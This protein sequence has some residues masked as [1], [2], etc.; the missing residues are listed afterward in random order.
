MD[1]KNDRIDTMLRR[2]ENLKY[3]LILDSLIVGILVGLV[4]VVHR[5]ILSGLSPIFISFYK[6]ASSNYLLIPVVFLVLILLGFIVGR[7]VKKEPMISGSG[8]PQVEG[9]L[10]RNLKQNWFMVLLYKFIGGLI[11]LGAGLSLGREGPSVQMG[12]CIGEGISKKTK[13]LDNE[14]KYLITSGAS[15][16]LSAAFNAPISGVMFSLEETHKNFSPLVLL[17]AMIASLTADFISKNFFGLTPSLYFSQLSSLPLKYYW[18]LLIL[19][20]VIGVSGV[21]FSNGLLKTQD[22]YKKINASVEVK[23]IIPFVITGIIGLI[24]PIVLGGGHDL[25]MTLKDSEF[26]LVFLLLVIV[27][28]FLFTFVCFGSGA[29]GG[30][31]FPLLVLG[32]LVG[33]F[34][35]IIYVK[36][37][38]IPG[39]YL[40]NF[41]VLAMAGHFASIVKAPITAI[42]L[43]SEMTGSLNHLLALAVVVIV[44][45]LT[46]DLLNSKPI[47]ES[48]LSRILSKG[49]NKYEGRVGKKTLIEIVVQ[50]YSGIDD[51]KIKDISWPENC[52][53]VSIHRGE[54][55]ILP[56]GDTKIYAGDL[57]LI[58]T[59]E[60]TAADMLE[61]IGEMAATI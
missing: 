52:L 44:S 10:T 42:L 53:L 19:G 9:I 15:A 39:I 13:K 6:K 27:I 40:V 35:G 7:M 2:L 48:L 8:I 26:T 56:K 29:P 51:R 45:Q 36:Y 30:I 4:I 1:I 49:T 54:K 58:M 41:I 34:V 17:S 43:I 24:F 37:L 57:L 59:N 23:C 3:K 31:F 50:V 47:Y 14:K 55:E 25:I 5:M 16:G 61:D 18:G 46:A 22:L 12:A 21:I 38:G 11:C 60:D 33:N 32:A 20:V 28:K